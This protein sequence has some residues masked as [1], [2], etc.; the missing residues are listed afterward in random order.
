MSTSL[1]VDLL[2]YGGLL[3]GFSAL[4]YC[5][6]PQAA[7]TTLWVGIP[8]GLL[9]ALLGV[10][11]LRGHA[12]RRWAIVVMAVLSIALLAQAVTGWRA[13]KA[14][15]E[16]ANQVALILIVLWGFAVVQ[17]MNLI[18]DRQGLLF[19]AGPKSH[20]PPAGDE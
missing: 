13:F 1:S 3:T 14:G 6:S 16:A 9:A 10:L 7:P 4:A 2:L 8:G 15:V 19:D 20:D 17:L 12:L 18:Q 11:G 5:L